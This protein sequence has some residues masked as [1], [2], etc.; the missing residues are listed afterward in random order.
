MLRNASRDTVASSLPLQGR[1]EVTADLV[2]QTR[3]ISVTTQHI[4]AA[5]R[6]ERNDWLVSVLCSTL[7]HRK[8][9]IDPALGR[10]A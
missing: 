8:A 10:D 6:P 5:R 3:V 2:R 1:P 9:W 4:N 7:P